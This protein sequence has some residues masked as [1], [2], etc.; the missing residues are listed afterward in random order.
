MVSMLFR[1]HLFNFYV[2][3]LL[4][5]AA[6]GLVFD[7]LNVQNQWLP[8]LWRLP[9]VLGAIFLLSAASFFMLIQRPFTK[10]LREMKALLTGRTYR[11]IM[12][13]KQNE[14]GVL[15]HFFNEV[16]RSLES[17]SGDMKTHQRLRKEIDSAQDI[18]QLLIP[19]KPP[20]IPG[21]SIS[22]KTR[23][24]SEIGGDTFDF[25]QKNNRYFIYIGDST[26]HGIPAGIV[27]VMVDALLETFIDLKDTVKDILI[28]LNKYLKPHLKPTMFMTM[29]LMEWMPESNTLK[30][31]GAGHE[32]LVHL[33]TKTNEIQSLKAGGLA[34][35]MLADN[36][37]YVHEQEV[38]LEENDFIVLYSDGIVEA[39]NRSGEIYSLNRLTTF[40]QSQVSA[41]TTP[42]ELFQKIAIDV[43]RFM[44]GE[45]QLDDMTLIVLKHTP[46]EAVLPVSSTDWQNNSPLPA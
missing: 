30:W 33:K 10:V 8:E 35:G 2:F 46:A 9:A 26:G 39:K 18:Q 16:T 11:R 14:V 31:G 32:Y 38:V 6:L 23:P 15:A 19:K 34:V 36:T 1:R 21:L 28:N 3:L 43:G 5:F 45:I 12:T 13:S 27:M 22:A 25:Y 44:E 40:I 42:D 37:P 4:L 29:I 20:L 41:D 24:A 17:I 7:Y